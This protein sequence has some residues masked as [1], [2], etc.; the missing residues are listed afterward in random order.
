MIKLV[1]VSKYYNS[2]NVVALG[3]RKVNL[4]LHRNEF[5]AI[6]GE[7][8]S[9]KTTLLNVISGIDSYEDGEIYVNGQETSYI[10]KL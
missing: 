6:V 1:N 8:G 3:L 7:S 5:V 10:S 2:N 4:E 9:G